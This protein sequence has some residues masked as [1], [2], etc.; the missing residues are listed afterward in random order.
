MT[1][2][3]PAVGFVI[4][5]NPGGKVY[6]VIVDDATG[7]IVWKILGRYSTRLTTFRYGEPPEGFVVDHAP[8]P[9]RPGARYRVAISAEGP[10]G[11][12]RFAI[13]DQGNASTAE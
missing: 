13:D 7:K 6:A 8:E 5:D 9:L 3:L 10:T 11:Y 1:E 2:R 12:L 4:A